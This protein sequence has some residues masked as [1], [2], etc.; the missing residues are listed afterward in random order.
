LLSQEHVQT[1]ADTGALLPA[2]G[3][4]GRDCGARAERF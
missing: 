4:A 3:L 1:H 2:T